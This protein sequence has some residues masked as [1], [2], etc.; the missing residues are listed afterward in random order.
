MVYQN[1][2]LKMV[3]QWKRWMATEIH[4]DHSCP[5]RKQCSPLRKDPLGDSETSAKSEAWCN[6]F[7]AEE[8]VMLSLLKAV[9]NLL[10]EGLNPSNQSRC[11][12]SLSVEGIYR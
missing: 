12:I 4:L 8:V 2:R 6:A 7:F 3:I 10:L 5:L 1:H 9:M 11:T